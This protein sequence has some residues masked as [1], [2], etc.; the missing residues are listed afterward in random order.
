MAKIKLKKE[1]YENKEYQEKGK[2]CHI[3]RTRRS[4]KMSVERF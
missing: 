1:E 4:S 2:A 3:L